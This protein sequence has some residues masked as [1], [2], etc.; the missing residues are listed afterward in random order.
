MSK[1]HQ[2]KIAEETAED[3][4][5]DRPSDRKYQSEHIMLRGSNDSDSYRLLHGKGSLGYNTRLGSSN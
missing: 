3:F 4:S 1:E 5:L 2:K